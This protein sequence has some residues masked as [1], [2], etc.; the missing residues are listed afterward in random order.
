MEWVGGI[1]S[2]YVTS[3]WLDLWKGK[4]IYWQSFLQIRSVLWRIWKKKITYRS[5]YIATITLNFREADFVKGPRHYNLIS[6]VFLW[7]LRGVHLYIGVDQC[8]MIKP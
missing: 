6:D 1:Q 4:L 7:L 5:L 8:I 3:V 2:T